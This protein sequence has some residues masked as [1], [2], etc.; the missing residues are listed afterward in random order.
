MRVLFLDDCNMFEGANP[1]ANLVDVFDTS[2]LIMKKLEE[3]QLG[4]RRR[5]GNWR[6]IMSDGNV[7]FNLLSSGRKSDYKEDEFDL[8]YRVISG[9]Y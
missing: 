1:I 2:E 7:K 6:E 5:G 8:E 9:N 3:S 4:V